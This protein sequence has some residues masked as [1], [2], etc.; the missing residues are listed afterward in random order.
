MA[1]FPALADIQ[2]TTS[3]GTPAIC[4]V[5]ETKLSHRPRTAMTTPEWAENAYR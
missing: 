2:G 1:T 5:T 4:Q 3:T